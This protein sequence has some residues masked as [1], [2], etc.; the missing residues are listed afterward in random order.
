LLELRRRNKIIRN[1]LRI[2]PVKSCRKYTQDYTG[3]VKGRLVHGGNDAARHL[4]A[5][6]GV[7]L[8]QQPPGRESYPLAFGL[9]YR[10]F[11]P[12][13]LNAAPR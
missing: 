4:P 10:W 13:N 8:Y 11:R 9:A 6:G 5:P 1:N 3:M 7:F 2:I 12:T